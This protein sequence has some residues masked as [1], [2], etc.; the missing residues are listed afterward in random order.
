MMLAGLPRAVNSHLENI[1][2]LCA[3]NQVECLKMTDPLVNNLL[4]LE[5]DGI[6]TYDAYYKKEVIVVAPVICVLADNARA[7][8]ITNHHGTSANK[9]CRIC[10]VRK[11]KHVIIIIIAIVTVRLRRMNGQTYYHNLAA[12]DRPKDK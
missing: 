3:S 11:S 10:Q 8:E 2:F 12:R 6:I 5:N 9:Y 7:S 1:H 4:A